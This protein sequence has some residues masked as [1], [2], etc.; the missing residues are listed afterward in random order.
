MYML[1]GATKDLMSQECTETLHKTIGFADYGGR[2]KVCPPSG[3]LYIR[4]S[5]QRKLWTSL[6]LTSRMSDSIF[7]TSS[8]APPR[9]LTA[10]RRW[11]LQLRFSNAVPTRLRTYKLRH[12]EK[13]RLLDRYPSVLSL[14]HGWRREQ[15]PLSCRREQVPVS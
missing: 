14:V 3:S 5:G 12:A 2:A 11:I 9:F 15:L 6:S 1:S 4:A 7:V 10:C 8:L 13:R